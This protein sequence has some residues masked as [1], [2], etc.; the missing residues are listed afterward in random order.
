M[1]DTVQIILL[2]VIVALTV[3]LVLL[4][5]QVFFI[6]KE[7]RNTIS[8]AN[9]VLDD[10]G[11]IAQSVSRPLASF[12]SIATGLKAGSILTIIKFAK[13]MLSKDEDEEK[14]SSK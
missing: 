2:L 7:F 13:N 9:K 3:L 10:T 12:S 6:L 11:L 4:G 1:V 14:K 5:I 8:K